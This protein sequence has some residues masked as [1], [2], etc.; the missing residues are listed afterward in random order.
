VIWHIVSVGDHTFGERNV[1][2]RT[3]IFNRTDS[4]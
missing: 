4:F 1:F 3:F 2:A